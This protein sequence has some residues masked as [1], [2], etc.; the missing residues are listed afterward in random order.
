[1]SMKKRCIRLLSLV[2][3]IVMIA[4][5]LEAPIGLL[6]VFAVD[7]APDNSLKVYYNNDFANNANGITFPTL[8]NGATNYSKYDAECDYLS[9]L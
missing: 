8:K 6:S 4:G 3:A 7:T 9:R 2:L 5:M 1:M